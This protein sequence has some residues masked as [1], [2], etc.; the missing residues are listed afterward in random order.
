M[1]RAGGRRRP[2]SFPHWRRS[3]MDG[4]RFDAIA[5]GLASPARRRGVLRGLGAGTVVA[6]LGTQVRDAVEA[7][8][9]TCPQAGC[10]E[11]CDNA[12]GPVGQPCPCVKTVNGTSV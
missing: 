5:R 2:P 11:T 9:V 12:V 4:A 6:L 3:P 1:L 8:A 10:K 7:A